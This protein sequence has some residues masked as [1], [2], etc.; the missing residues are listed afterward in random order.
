MESLDHASLQRISAAKEGKSY[1]P[2]QARSSGGASPPEREIHSSR[3]SCAVGAE[4]PQKPDALHH[5]P[6]R[7]NVCAVQ[8]RYQL[9]RSS[10]LQVHYSRRAVVCNAL[11]L[12]AAA[13]LGGPVTTWVGPVAAQQTTQ[14][15][16]IEQF[17]LALATYQYKDAYALLSSDLQAK[18]SLDAFTKGYADTAYVQA[19]ITG[20]SAS[21][22]QQDIQVNITSWHN[23]RSI[24]AYSGSY[25]LNQVGGD[26]KIATSSIKEEAPPQDVAPLMRFSDL[27]VTLGKGS[28]G[29]GHRYFD[30]LV[31]NT[32]QDTVTAAD[33]PHLRLLD[34]SGGVVME[35]SSAQVQPIT[36]VALQAGETAHATC[37]WTN[38]CTKA[39]AFPLRLQIAIP[40]DTHEQT[41][42]FTRSNQTPPC[43]GSAEVT[44]FQ[45]QA[46]RAGQQ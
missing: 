42:P 6:Q 14:D 28:A 19:Q 21:A 23:D 1:T 5:G 36:A 10:L 32:A 11:G 4:G 29:L 27:D 31:T 17:Y 44:I 2:C 43:V 46:F 38:W 13:S 3:R 39:P 20:N 37:E 26:W 40:G 7:V 25:T 45:S 41:I 24:H 30:L 33:V 15:S 8:H 34:R 18:Q 35:S 12:A 16:A 9:S 22:G